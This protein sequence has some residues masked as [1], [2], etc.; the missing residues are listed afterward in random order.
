MDINLRPYLRPDG[1]ARYLAI[2]EAIQNAFIAGHLQPGMR[3]PTHRELAADLRVSVQTISRA[4][5]QAEKLG[6]VHGVIGSGTYVSNYSPDQ[7]TEFFQSG[8]P[9]TARNPIDLSIAHPVCT[10]RHLQIVREAMIRVAQSEND[11]YLLKFRPVSGLAEH[12]AAGQ[13]WLRG[14]GL[15]A[16]HD[17]IVL[18]N[19]TAHGLMLALASIVNPGETIACEELVD[20]GF[21]ALARTLNFR[22]TGLP[23]DEEGLVPE[24]LEVACRESR[25][26]ILCCT[27][28][29]NNPTGSLMP[30]KRREQIAAIARRY[31]L[32]VV[33][34][35]VFGALEPKRCPPLASLIPERTF[36]ATSFTKT[37]LPGLRAGYLV[38]PDCFRKQVI[39]HLTASTWMATPITFELV[40]D[41]IRENLLDSMIFTQQDELASRQSLARSLLPEASVGG[42]PFGMHIWLALPDDMT[43]QEMMERCREQGVLVTPCQQFCPSPRLAPRRVR[44]SL[45]SES[46]RPRL[47]EGLQI[48]RNIIEA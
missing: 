27:P 40:S 3:L 43:S 38:I 37:V 10:K 5:S 33:E 1:R 35:D 19:G 31:D 47:Q 22:L 39:A 30:T 4:Y 24:A 21:I 11:Q 14:Q 13:H 29:L 34:D 42:S 28:S 2:A 25:L 36:Y 12:V 20:H 15:P 26:R 41:L 7:E 23:I 46:Y 32:L 44:V 6:V 16:S 17:N 45:G 18:C 8:H 48:V 9:E